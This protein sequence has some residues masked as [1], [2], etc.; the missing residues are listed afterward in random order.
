MSDLQKNRSF[1]NLNRFSFQQ[2]AASEIN[3]HLRYFWHNF[4][5]NRAI[6]F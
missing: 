3:F 4:V 6:P 5:Q 1:S 2:K